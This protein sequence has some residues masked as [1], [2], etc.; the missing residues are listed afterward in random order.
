MTPIDALPIVSSPAGNF[1]NPSMLINME[2]AAR[3]YADSAFV[4]DHFRGN[5]A[6]VLIA[7]DMALLMN[8]NA[9]MLM[10]TMYIIH[11]KPGFEAK[12]VIALMNKSGLFKDPLEYEWRSER[13]KSD[14]GCRATAVRRSTGKKIEGPWVDWAMVV[15][16]GWNV[17][18]KKKDGG[19]QKS[20]WNTM[21]ELM[22]PYRAA[23]FFG[24]LNCPDLLMG[25]QTADE[26]EDME[27]ELKRQP[28]GGFAA[29]SEQKKVIPINKDLYTNTKSAPAAETPPEQ[30][31]AETQGQ[32]P[33][34]PEPDDE[35]IKSTE[36]PESDRFGTFLDHPLAEPKWKMAKSGSF[37]RGSGLKFY[38]HSHREFF[39]DITAD[40]YAAI[41]EK[42]S[43]VYD[44]HDIP[45][46]RN[47]DIITDAYTHKGDNGQA[48]RQAPPPNDDELIPERLEPPVE[49]KHK[50]N[51]TDVQV[52]AMRRMDELAQSNPMEFNAVVRGRTPE[53]L[54]QLLEWMGEINELIVEKQINNGGHNPEDEKF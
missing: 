16:E 23:T 53:T 25:M 30:P 32:A 41:C 52:K 44:G 45:W 33:K 43:Q 40:A 20:K 46:D 28:G 48:S 1:L 21:P 24:R 9:F 8:M 13:G 34:P 26:L 47:G 19:F 36:A 27:I 22:F 49:P 6:N 39:R 29:A 3:I 18:K 4:P 38:L 12:F 15:A 5:I 17:D 42:Y 31:P 51:T 54:E 7:M 50:D 2:K 11:G 14:W 37:E 10:R 35:P